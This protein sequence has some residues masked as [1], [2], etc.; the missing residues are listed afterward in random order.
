MM[1][2][3]MHIAGNG[4]DKGGRGNAGLQHFTWDLKRTRGPTLL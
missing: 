3:A 2:Q 4:V 1:V